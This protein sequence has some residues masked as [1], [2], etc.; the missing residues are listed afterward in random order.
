VED[1]S[2]RIWLA[3]LLCCAAGGA[4][5]SPA[6]AAFGVNRWE[7]GTCKEKACNSEG[8]DPAAEF[9]TQAAGHPDF[10]ITDFAFDYTT[11]TNI[12]AEEVRAPVGH[13]HDVRVDLP[14][15][16]AVDPEAA[17]ECPE[18]QIEALECPVS[19]QVGEDEAQGTAELALGIRKTVTESFPVY[20]LARRPGEPARF[21][22]EVKSSTLALAES[23]SATKL[24]SAIYLE[25]GISWHHE[26]ETAEN[27]GVPSGDYHE[28]FEIHNVPTQ[29]ELVESRLIFWGVPQEHTLTGEAPRAFITMPSSQSVCA[30]PSTT[31]LHVDSY[32]NEGTF[33]KYA[34]ETRLKNGTPIVA[35]GCN[36]LA[37]DPSLSLAPETSR[38]DQPDGATVDLHIPQLISQPSQPD[39]PDLQN[40]EVS[41]PEGMTLNPAAAHGLEGCSNAQIKLGTDEK[42]ECPAGSE[43]GTVTVNA[44]GIP[45]GS[46]VGKV[47]LGAPEP[48]G[49]ESGEEFRIFLAAEAPQYGVGLRLEGHVQANVQSG[50]LTALFSE[51][52]QVPFED[53]ILTFRG[54]PTTPFGRGAPP[55]ANP[56][57]CGLAEPAAALTPYTGEPA[58][59]AQTHG[60]TVDANGNGGSCS[61]PLPFAPVQTTPPQSPAGAGAYS[62]FMLQLTRGEGQQYLS[63][64]QTTLAPGLLGAIPA[65][66]LCGEAQANAGT[67][68]SASEVGTVAVSAG[69][70]PEPFPFTGHAYITG[71]YDGAPYGLSIVVSAAAGP[72]NF[73]EVITRAS[74]GVGLYNGRLVVSSTL[75]TIVEGVPLR[76][77]SLSV[78]VNRPNFLFNPTNCEALATESQLSGFVPGSSALTEQSV[79]SPFQVGEC[80]KLAFT[81]KLTAT[82]GK[83]VSRV[84]GA[85]LEIKVTQGAHQ[86]DIRAVLASLPKQLATR[87]TTLHK[88]CPAAT[89]EAGPPP[90]GC[91]A[92]ARVG[93][94]T[95]ATPVLPAP[96]AGPAYLVSHGGEAYPDLDVVLSGDGV[97]VV[98]VGHTHIAARTGI[99][100][101]AFETLPDVPISSFAL[102]LPTGPHSVLTDN[103]NGTLC[104]SHLAMPT[105]IVAQNGARIAQSTKI[106]VGN[107]PRHRHKQRRHRRRRR[108]GARMHRP[109]RRR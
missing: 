27:S 82:T 70:G 85:S 50:R 87:I 94:A 58:Q 42:I 45:N 91:G 6:G 28:F 59:A 100:S 55:L 56:L 53:F 107:C 80:N 48:G 81:P 102:N 101:S 72:Y 43:I 20:N 11:E 35:T 29:P 60:F 74:I 77:R 39:S 63:K 83:R 61:T 54:G 89:F 103:H 5:A 99:L 3:V 84:D 92:E 79:S 37:L 64:L 73:G 47:Y 18:A 105:T 33:F 71:P 68:P 10:G 93:S 67:C 75:P 2:A 32:E 108:R 25:G 40:V 65:V 9:Y 17:K 90:G 46:L 4:A 96:L 62:P 26:A 57:R 34:D 109:H 1:R 76:L 24:Q 52:P 31:Y 36:A 14:P 51:D 44:P 97:E 16:L 7:A 23:I 21:G 30:S 69:A 98:L 49:A 19:T 106:A 38:S 8:K 15:G 13:V 95:V 41:L 22:V 88:A 12:L 86:A 104:G 66:T 78:A